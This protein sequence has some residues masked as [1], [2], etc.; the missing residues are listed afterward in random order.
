MNLKRYALM[1]LHKET[2]KDIEHFGFQYFRTTPNRVVLVVWDDL[3]KQ[4]AAIPIVSK[5]KRFQEKTWINIHPDYTWVEIL[6][7]K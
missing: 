5:E 2:V 3:L 4:K 6:R 7:I 1:V